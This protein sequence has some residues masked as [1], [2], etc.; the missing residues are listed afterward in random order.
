[1]LQQSQASI[2]AFG[3]S[4]INECNL[5]KPGDGSEYTVPQTYSQQHQELGEVR[6]Q[7]WLKVTFAHPLQQLFKVYSFWVK[8]GPVPRPYEG[9]LHRNKLN[10]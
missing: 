6:A 7:R 1:M 8:F 4:T 5:E 2:M 10:S 9:P 3:G